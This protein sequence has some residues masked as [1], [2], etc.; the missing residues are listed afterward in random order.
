MTFASLGNGESVFV[1]ANVFVYHFSS[2]A[3]FGVACRDLIE[4]IEQGRLFG[5]TSTHILSEVSHRMMIIEAANLPGWGATNIRRRL[6]QKPHTIGGLSFFRNAVQAIVSS[7]VRVLTPTPHVVVDGTNVSQ[8]SL[9]LSNDA[10]TV[11]MMQHHGLV[12][13]ASG[14]AD[15]DRVPGITRFAPA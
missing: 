11:A 9:L 8:Q 4:R 14:D 13:L 6:Q 15:F 10:L 12:N 1:D 7:S 3:T 2:H 5:F